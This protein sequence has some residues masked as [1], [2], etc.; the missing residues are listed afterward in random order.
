MLSAA[1]GPGVGM[2]SKRRT[3]IA[4]Y[5][6]L[7][8]ALVLFVPAVREIALDLLAPLLDLIRDVSPFRGWSARPAPAAG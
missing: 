8:L 4:P 7:L 3:G 1:H 2:A 5:V 6:A